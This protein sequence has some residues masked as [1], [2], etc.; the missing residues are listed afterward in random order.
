M[1]DERSNA[2]SMLRKKKSSMLAMPLAGTS[3]NSNNYVVV[4]KGKPVTK[5]DKDNQLMMTREDYFKV[6]EKQ[7]L[8]KMEDTLTSIMSIK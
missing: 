7:D 4:K 3:D 5:Y 6:V 1:F 2:G 8:N